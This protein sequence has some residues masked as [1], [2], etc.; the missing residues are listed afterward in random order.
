MSCDGWPNHR[1]KRKELLYA[2][3]TH[4]LP[5]ASYVVLEAWPKF[6]ALV[7]S[8]AEMGHQPHQSQARVKTRK[9]PKV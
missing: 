7:K 5:E 6:E 8:A 4:A 9:R 1:G 3:T 2:T